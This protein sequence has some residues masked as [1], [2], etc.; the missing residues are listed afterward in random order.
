MMYWDYLATRRVQSHGDPPQLRNLCHKIDRDMPVQADVKPKIKKAATPSHGP[1]PCARCGAAAAKHV[2]ET[3]VVATPEGGDHPTTIRQDLCGACLVGHNVAVDRGQDRGWSFGEVMAYDESTLRP[4]LLAFLS[5]EEEWALVSP[6]P[7]A[8]YLDFFDR[9][10]PSPATPRSLLARGSLGSFSARGSLLGSFS[11]GS[12]SASSFSE[13]SSA[14]AGT[15]FQLYDDQKLVSVAQSAAAISFAGSDDALFAGAREPTAGRGGTP[16]APL[17]SPGAGEE[18]GPTPGPVTPAAV[19]GALGAPKRTPRT[20]AMWTKEEDAVL[21]RVVRSFTEK[22]E[23]FRWQQVSVSFG[24]WSIVTLIEVVWPTVD[25]RRFLESTQAR[26]PNRTGKQCRERYLNHLSPALKSKVWSPE[27]DYAIFSLFFR[28]GS[29]WSVVARV[30]R[31]RCVA[32][33]EAAAL[34][35]SRQFLSPLRSLPGPTTGSRTASTIS[36]AGWTETPPRRGDSTPAWSR[37]RRR[38]RPRPR[39]TRQSSSGRCGA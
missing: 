13:T 8:D 17:A 28:I 5:G 24:G 15:T 32:R 29:K 6:T 27:E 37:T 38:P 39:A 18:E 3:Y 34:R 2:I 12:F 19:A 21:Q 30:L 11:V 25:C 31:G 4:F 22:D 36:G 16:A 26:V 20:P 23:D 7:T 14:D 10:P 35:V 1:T 33:V 9:R